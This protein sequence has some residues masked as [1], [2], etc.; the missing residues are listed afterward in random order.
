LEEIELLNKLQELIKSGDES[1]I[2]LAFEL[3]KGQHISAEQLLP[4][5]EPL[6]KF[7]EAHYL[8][9]IKI[10]NESPTQI[11]SKIVRTTELNSIVQ[12][13]QKTIKKLPESIGLMVNLKELDLVNNHLTTLPKSIKNL[14]HLGSLNIIN[15]NIKFL[16]KE[17]KSLSNLDKIFWSSNDIQVLPS[18]LNFPTTLKFLTLDGNKLK[19]VPASLGNYVDLKFLNLS[20]NLLETVPKSFF[21][22]ENLKVLHIEENRLSLKAK[23]KIRAHL[24]NCRVY[25]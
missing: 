15:N 6:I 13:D 16:P 14:V 11:L 18:R 5:W 17:I 8:D 4:P 24:P 19:K 12:F 23:Q 2:E 9:F 22:L 21:K 7:L 10:R 25:F 3:G 20:N 1:N